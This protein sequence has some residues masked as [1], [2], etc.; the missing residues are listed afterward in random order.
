MFS[1]TIQTWRV[2][3]FGLQSQILSL[4]DKAR[5]GGV[6]KSLIIIF[7]DDRERERTIYPAEGQS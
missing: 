1:K 6:E 5:C 3:Q 4:E 2:W 7:A